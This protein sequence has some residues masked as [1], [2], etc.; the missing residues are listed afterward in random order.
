MKTILFTFFNVLTFI[1]IVGQTTYNWNTLPTHNSSPLFI[2]HIY[3]NGDIL[4][5]REVPLGYVIS[6]DDGKTWQELYLGELDFAQT[7]FNR[8]MRFREDQNGDVYFRGHREIY[9]LVDGNELLIYTSSQS[10]E[11]FEFLQNGNIAVAEG[12]FLRIINKY[13]VRL[14]EENI[15]HGDSKIMIGSDGVHYVAERRGSLKVRMFNDD[16][17]IL[18]E[19]YSVLFGKEDNFLSNGRLFSGHQFSDDGGQTWTEI[20]SDL[21]G[22]YSSKL[23]N[24]QDE[25]VLVSDDNKLFLSKDLGITF[26]ELPAATLEE[27]ALEFSSLM[28][29][30]TIVIVGH[31]CLQSITKISYDLGETW[32]TNYSETGQSY[33]NDV[34]VDFDANILMQSCNES[35]FS[36]EAGSNDWI[37]T[38]EDT[39][40]RFDTYVLPDNTFLRTSTEGISKSYDAGQTWIPKFSTERFDLRIK[41][42]LIVG[43]NIEGH[44]KDNMII[45]QDNGES[46]IELPIISDASFS[47]NSNKFDIL[48][49]EK[50]VSWA[51][52]NTGN[53]TNTVRI[54]DLELESCLDLDIPDEEGFMEGIVTSFN[55]PNF[56]VLINNASPDD[57][58]TLYF[59]KNEGG[60]FEK[61]NIP[62]ILPYSLSDPF[63][64]IDRYENLYLGH[65]DV[66]YMSTDQG[67]SWINI[68]NDFPSGLQTMTDVSIGYDDHIYISNFGQGLLKSEFKVEDS[69]EV[70]TDAIL[71]VN[72]FHDQNED[73]SFQNNEPGFENFRVVYNNE[74]IK[75]TNATGNAFFFSTVGV[76]EISLIYNEDFY[77]SCEDSYLVFHIGI[78]D[79]QELNIPVKII[80]ECIF[81]ESS[82]ASNITRRCFE[83]SASAQI[84]N[85]GTVTTGNEKVFIELDP[86]FDLLSSSIPIIS[87]DG[88]N[89]EFRTE[90]LE[91]G[92]CMNI[93]I[94]YEVNCEAELGQLHCASIRTEHGNDC[95]EGLPVVRDRNFCVENIGSYDPNDKNIVVNDVQ[96]AAFVEE[97]DDLEY[98]IR[99]QNTGTDTA[100]TVRIEDYLSPKFDYNTV[101]PLVASH[102]FTWTLERGKLEVLFED[103]LLVDSFT[104]EPASH[105]FVRFKVELLDAI[106]IGESFENEASIY[107]D[108][109]DPI[110]TNLVSATFDNDIDGDG[111]YST[112]DC[113]DNNAD[114]NPN[115]AEVPYNGIDDD[116]DAAT[117]DDDL[118]QDGFVLAEDCDDNNAD[119]NPNATE[120]PY[121]GMDDDCDA[122][123]FDDDLDQ[124]GYV[125]AEDCD[126]NNANIYPNAEEV[127]NNGIDEDCDG[128]DLITSSTSTLAQ[129]EI[130]L[131]PNPV[132]DRFI[133]QSTEEFNNVVLYDFQGKSIRTG[134]RSNQFIDISDLPSGIYLL[135]L[136][137]RDSTQKIYRKIVVSR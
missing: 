90:E 129:I 28:Q 41:E 102:D 112:V 132:N 116:C 59:S 101:R 10:I 93:R 70:E 23:M 103:I 121:N 76:Q 137:P 21:F 40:S 120:L 22:K 17:S 95:Y 20:E 60:S 11:D 84:C 81:L 126:D 119:I 117:L 134:L 79:F 35:Y 24:V 77:E 56:Y 78:E 19:A 127:P 92:R 128:E 32:T 16:L 98:L 86:Y 109:N 136:T 29:G 54:C 39:D 49:T 27:E 68:S 130:T 51:T 3:K 7:I 5:R 6:K 45:S 65:F 80:N 4:A 57:G 110:I 52:S 63:F 131:L 26:E 135:A 108:F 34:A 122:A 111:Y 96:G 53:L 104:N 107:F 72:V 15:W 118:D 42:E 37:H 58:H 36:L 33:A 88:Q 113:D 13:G 30:N 114:I 18:G 83:S 94:E 97:G 133:I 38:E 25:N 64:K 2:E 73:C 82:I 105:G 71:K 48:T 123:T 74:I 124:D 91:P 43:Y 75:P 85:Q 46:W 31:N 44:K 8:H 50:Y 66:L 106:E 100:F 55:T 47:S 9:K 69:F 89:L 12:N 62:F 125:L 1:S 14:Y 87:Q 99:F 61:K 67:T 115:I